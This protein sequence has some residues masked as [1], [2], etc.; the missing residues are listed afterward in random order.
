M[1]LFT[2]HL[3]QLNGVFTESTYNYSEISAI[4]LYGGLKF[5]KAFLS[6]DLSKEW[7]SNIRSQSI[8][9]VAIMMAFSQSL[10]RTTKDNLFFFE[11]N[12]NEFLTFML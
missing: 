6:L 5:E 11:S 1:H 9:L 2:D 7:T 8:C 12:N 4:S 3:T 10:Q